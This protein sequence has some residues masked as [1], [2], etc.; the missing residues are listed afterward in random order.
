MVHACGTPHELSKHDA[1]K[2]FS[3]QAETAGPTTFPPTQTSA[4]LPSSKSDKAARET[5]HPSSAPTADPP[6]NSQ[7]VRRYFESSRQ[8][9]RRHRQRPEPWSPSPP[10][11][12]PASPE[13]PP[14]IA[15]A[16][17]SL[18]FRRQCEGRRA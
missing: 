1:D 17:R 13:Y 10:G 2:R 5:I 4:S 6:T 16:D 3:L 9:V 14:E 15:S 7:P 11:A 8:P 18:P 12:P